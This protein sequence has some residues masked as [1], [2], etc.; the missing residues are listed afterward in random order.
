MLQIIVLPSSLAE[1][2]FDTVEAFSPLA[3][4]LR[5]A[6]KADSSESHSTVARILS[7]DRFTEV[8]YDSRIDAVVNRYDLKSTLCSCL[9]EGAVN[10]TR[11]FLLPTISTNHTSPHCCLF[12]T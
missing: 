2:V 8:L 11:N 7:C 1:V 9:R 3:A 4:M 12:H 6:T 5:A 10:G